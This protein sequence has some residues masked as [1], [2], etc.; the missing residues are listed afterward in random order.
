MLALI[1]Q[2][3][4]HCIALDHERCYQGFDMKMAALLFPSILCLVSSAVLAEDRSTQLPLA[5]QLV[6][7]AAGDLGR[8]AVTA[9]MA[10]VCAK[11]DSK[12]TGFT[13]RRSGVVVTN[14]HVVAS[15]SAG[16]LVAL[17]SQGKK[18]LFTRLVKDDKRDLALIF[19]KER[20]SG[21]LQLAAD[22]GDLKPGQ[23]VVTWGFPLAYSGPAPLFVLGYVSGFTARPDSKGGPVVDRLVVNGAFNP[24]NSGGPV[25]K[26]NEDK[27]IGIVVSKPDP[28][29]PVL[30]NAIVA[31]SKTDFG[32]V[33]SGTDANGNKVQLSDSQIIAMFLEYVQKITQVVIGEAIPVDD[34]RALLKQ[35]NI[36][37]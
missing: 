19:P 29:P 18:L 7:D 37:E 1:D 24:G 34:L 32:V 3:R 17:S 36:A 13:L 20:I 6:L 14:A 9:V 23:A 5:T 2:A 35:E 12:G 8:S 16:E 10:V 4:R 21:G 33:H 30:K 31:L 27:V 26:T 28:M 25:L 11:A 15:C 22:I